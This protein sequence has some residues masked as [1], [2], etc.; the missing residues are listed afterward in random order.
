MV[1]LLLAA[2]CNG[3]SVPTAP[4]PRPVVPVVLRVT[5]TPIRAEFLRSVGTASHFRATAEITVSDV[6]DEGVRID[7]FTV[8]TMTT[9]QS[10][11]GLRFTIVQ[12]QTTP[13]F[14]QIPA[15]GAFTQIHVLEFAIGAGE[16]MTCSFKVAGVDGR[17]RPFTASTPNIT[18]ELI[19]PGG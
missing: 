14:H 15:R 8:T 2:S 4:A 5:P 10:E 6:G 18:V 1:A 9:A 7:Q 19:A 17:G 13:V 16:T 12:P 3:A 11:Q